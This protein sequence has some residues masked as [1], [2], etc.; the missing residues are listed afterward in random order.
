M[1]TNNIQVFL[2]CLKLDRPII[3]RYETNP[4]DMFDYEATWTNC[5][6]CEN[7]CENETCNAHLSDEDFLDGNTIKECTCVPDGFYGNKDHEIRI[8]NNSNK[9]THLLNALKEIEKQ[10]WMESYSL[11]LTNDGI[12]EV[13][14]N[15]Y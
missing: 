9:E 14:F 1:T 13:R 3:L 15:H 5:Q 12:L 6:Y 11:T 4:P 7:N 10:M 2:Q 8:D